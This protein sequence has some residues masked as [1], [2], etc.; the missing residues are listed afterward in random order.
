MEGAGLGQYGTADPG[1]VPPLE[2]PGVG[3]YFHFVYLLDIALELPFKLINKL[4]EHGVPPGYDDVVENIPFDIQ[5]QILVATYKIGANA[6]GLELLLGDFKGLVHPDHL[7]VRQLQFQ[8]FVLARVLLQK[9][10]DL[11]LIKFYIQLF[12]KNVVGESKIAVRQLLLSVAHPVVVAVGAG[13]LL[14]E[15]LPDLVFKY[16]IGQRPAVPVLL[17][18]LVQEEALVHNRNLGEVLARLHDDPVLLPVRKA[19]QHPLLNHI[20]ALHILLLEHQLKN[21][22]LV[23]G[24]V[25]VAHHNVALLK[26]CVY[27]SHHIVQ[28]PL[29][30][31]HVSYL[32]PFYHLLIFQISLV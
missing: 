24:M 12:Q 6:V 25:K 23:P 9:F 1:G 32:L 19:C 2:G 28:V 29:K 3:H 18:R 4:G 17:H 26:A 5:V 20:E 22:F 8:S 11:L 10:R 27:F 14:V 30:Q 31:P 16:L 21:G 13:Q 15:N 7:L